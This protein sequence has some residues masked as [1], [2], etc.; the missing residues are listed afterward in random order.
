[1]ALRERELA[2]NAFVERAPV[3]RSGEAVEL[4]RFMEMFQRFVLVRAGEGES[5]KHVRA[6][7]DSVSIREEATFYGL[8]SQRRPIVSPEIFQHVF[9]GIR[10]HDARVLAA[11][12]GVLDADV[13]ASRAPDDRLALCQPM[14]GS[15]IRTGDY[16]TVA[17]LKIGAFDVVRV[18]SLSGNKGPSSARPPPSGTARARWSADPPG[19]GVSIRCPPFPPTCIG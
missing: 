9:A 12:C 17:R 3:H 6:Q 14:N 13:A 5:Q 10:A 18:G 15:D 1:M 4:H 16:H 11:D 8:L 2:C 7:A 19:G